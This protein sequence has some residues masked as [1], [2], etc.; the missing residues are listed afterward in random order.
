MW[1]WD[2][3]VEGSPTAL[4]GTLQGDIGRA[5]QSTLLLSC[6]LNTALS[7]PAQ[8]GIGL[9][10]AEPTH[11]TVNAHGHVLTLCPLKWGGVRGPLR[12]P[13]SHMAEVAMLVEVHAKPPGEEGGVRPRC[14]QALA[15]GPAQSWPRRPG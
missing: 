7:Q 1:A 10:Q 3:E 6:R 12:R 13:L 9:A 11:P 15:G 4:L 2:R 14:L 5:D 8:R